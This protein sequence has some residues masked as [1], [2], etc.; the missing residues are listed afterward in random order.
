[1]N[2]GD[3]CERGSQLRPNIVWFGEMVPMMDVAVK[4]TLTADIFMV[5]G[6]SMVIYPAAGLIDYVKTDTPKFI[7]DPNMP[8]V[9]QRENLH[10]IEEKATSGLDKVKDILLADYL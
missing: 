10:L 5:V 7:I 6:T 8:N 4:E 3:K 1:M 9:Y 2:L